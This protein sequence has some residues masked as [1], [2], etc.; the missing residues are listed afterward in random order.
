[1]ER[2][3][4]KEKTQWFNCT[5]KLKENMERTEGGKES[6]KTMTKLETGATKYDEHYNHISCKTE[7]ARM[8]KKYTHTRDTIEKQTLPTKG[9][10]KNGE[11]TQREKINFGNDKPLSFHCYFDFGDVPYFDMVR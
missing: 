7:M 2:I 4:L 1:M 11:G 10:Y 9:K 3:T 8:K 5:N 6:G